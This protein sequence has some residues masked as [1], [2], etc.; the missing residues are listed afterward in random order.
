M[1]VVLFASNNVLNNWRNFHLQLV[2]RFKDIGFSVVGSFSLP[3]PVDRTFDFV[4]ITAPHSMIYSLTPA[5]VIKVCDEN[6]INCCLAGVTTNKLDT[7]CL[8]T[9]SGEEYMGHSNRTI[10]GISC[11]R[12][13]EKFPHVHVYDD[14]KYFPDYSTN[15]LGYIHDINN[16]CRNPSLLSSV[17][18]QPWCFTTNQKVEKEYC[19]IPKCKSKCIMVMMF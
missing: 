3:H 6:V 4:N 5:A 8:S 16:Y 11:Q 19:D 12:W 18:A 9:P 14:I 1:Y 2:C 7:E 10:S 15:P 13:G 17:D